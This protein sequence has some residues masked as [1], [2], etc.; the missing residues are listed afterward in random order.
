METTSGQRVALFTVAFGSL[1]LI[2]A[3][4]SDGGW[5][6]VDEQAHIY[7]VNTFLRHGFSFDY[8][9]TSATTPGVHLLFAGLSYLL[10]IVPLTTDSI[11]IPLVNSAFCA[12]TLVVAY[13]L[14]VRL[15]QSATYGLLVV[16]AIASSSY[17]MKAAIYLVT[18]GPVYLAYVALLSIVVVSRPGVASGLLLAGIGGAMVGVRQIMMPI[19]GT[20]GLF[21]LHGN[22]AKLSKR[23]AMAALACALPVL[24]FLPFYLAWGGAVPSNFAGHSVPGI[25]FSMLLHNIALAGF[26]GVPFLA[27]ARIEE[28][29]SFAASRWLWWAI[30]VA[31][32]I[33][34]VIP[35]DANAAAGREFSI[36]WRIAAHSPV[37]EGRALLLLPPVGL[38][39]L[40][41]AFYIWKAE[42]AGRVPYEWIMFALLTIGYMAQKFSWQRYPE[43]L[44]IMTLAVSAA[45][46]P[47]LSRTGVLVFAGL[48]GLYLSVSLADL[49][50]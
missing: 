40:T 8:L 48:F 7:Q 15:S 14:A 5:A 44:L 12:A 2:G 21:L 31:L 23:F 43:V 9:S 49:L 38:G 1:I 25:N 13:A 4:A 10:G 39:A 3:L 17:F 35:S 42:Q 47:R 28:L 36:V 19:S 37:I 33:W 45:Y 22:W 46:G 32:V 18:E 41:I 6:E 16:L 26:F 20:A 30:G 34:L 27:L 24:V 50:I 11:L 29:K